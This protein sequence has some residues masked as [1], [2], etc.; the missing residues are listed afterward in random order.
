M[1]PAVPPRPERP[2]T[3]GQRRGH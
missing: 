2:D 3:G 1:L